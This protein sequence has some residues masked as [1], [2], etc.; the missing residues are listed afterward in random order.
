L[1]KILLWNIVTRLLF[2]R[3]SFV[4]KKLQLS[5]QSMSER[6][7]IFFAESI[8]PTKELAWVNLIIQRWFEIAK[9]NFYFLEKMKYLIL[10]KF[11]FALKQKLIKSIKINK[12]SFKDC[13]YVKESKCLGKDDY[14]EI[15]FG[16][17]MKEESSDEED[18]YE[19]NHVLLLSK[20]VFNGKV[21]VNMTVTLP[22]NLIYD[23]EISLIAFEGDV[24]FR[25][26]SKNHLTRFDATFVS[27]PNFE[28]YFKGEEDHLKIKTLKKIFMYTLN[29]NV[30]Y[31][32]WNSFYLPMLVPSLKN[33]AHPEYKIDFA[34]YKSIAEEIELNIRTYSCLDYKIMKKYE[35]YTKRRGQ[36]FINETHRIIRYDLNLEKEFPFDS[37]YDFSFFK[38]LFSTFVGLKQ[39]KKLDEFVSIVIIYFTDASYQFYRIK[40]ENG[41]IFQGITTNEFIYFEIKNKFLLILQFV[42][43]KNLEFTEQRVERIS[44]KFL[45]KKSKTLGSVKL[46]SI[47]SFSREKAN[48]YFKKELIYPENCNLSIKQPEMEKLFEKI[49]NMNKDDWFVK[50][51]QLKNKKILFDSFIRLHL[52]GGVI[53]AQTEKENG[54]YTTI[55][56]DK[57]KDFLVN[58]LEEEN[59]IIDSH[60][61]N[62]NIILYEIDEENLKITSREKII[63]HDVLYFATLLKF[64]TKFTSLENNDKF[65]EFSWAESLE[66]PYSAKTGS[67]YLEFFNKAETQIQLSIYEENTDKFVLRKILIPNS[68]NFL[69]V[70]PSYEGKYILKFKAFVKYNQWSKIKMKQLT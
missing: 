23:L 19:F 37:F 17:G 56:L 16:L 14:D 7:K 52:F 12:L 70:F 30:I 10:K 32:C 69:F 20:I 25:I 46:H 65:D 3:T 55:I 8:K 24:I 42:L 58:S 45:D 57:D 66:I 62:K 35:S 50:E 53:L 13:P 22:G 18:E 33:I 63:S 47:L 64:Y 54:V 15:I 1:L 68:A 40:S 6:Q 49:K 28:V 51:L 5:H 60:S 41:I 27:N 2:P 26:P 31:P 67:V 48:V 11:S 29:K 39:I 34:N 4:K 9:D 43:S 59:I 21:T 44:R 61:E 38:D 36:Y